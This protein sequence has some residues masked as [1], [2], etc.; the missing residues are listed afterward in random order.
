ML[1][2]LIDISP[3]LFLIRE[4]T[5]IL[6]YNYFDFPTLGYIYNTHFNLSLSSFIFILED[7]LERIPAR[8]FYISFFSLRNHPLNS[9]T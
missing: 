7:I 9:F 3:E 2:L 1:S 8:V 6:N 5:I 4:E